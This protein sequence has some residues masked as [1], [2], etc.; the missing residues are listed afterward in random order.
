MVTG[1]DVNHWQFIKSIF[2]LMMAS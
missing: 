2:S 1:Y